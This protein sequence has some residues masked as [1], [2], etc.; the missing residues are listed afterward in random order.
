M[1]K[2]IQGPDAFSREQE[3]LLEMHSFRNIGNVLISNIRLIEMTVRR[4]NRFPQSTHL[5]HDFIEHC[6]SPQNIIHF[7]DALPADNGLPEVI[8]REFYDA[9]VTHPGVAE[10]IWQQSEIILTGIFDI[11]S[12]R[13]LELRTRYAAPDPWIKIDPAHLRK[14]LQDF[15]LATAQNSRG[16]FGV[17][18]DP[19]HQ[20]QIDYLFTFTFEGARESKLI[21]PNIFTDT[22]RDL[23]ANSRKYSREGTRIDLRIHQSLETLT[24][25][26]ADQGRGIPEREISSVVNI[27][28]RGSNTGPGETTGGGMGLTK[29]WFLTQKYHGKMWID[30]QINHG[31]TMT[32]ELP[33]PLS[34]KDS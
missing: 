7:C 33:L 5:L 10:A 18:F 3:A 24:I 25:E 9:R 19:A 21:M 6:D 26:V 14:S 20:G 16:R 13:L 23:I 27:G 30:S 1:K 32:I 34:S 4:E 11:F 31:T 12:V 29:A 8:L 15:L 28:V 2:L 17:V 22:I